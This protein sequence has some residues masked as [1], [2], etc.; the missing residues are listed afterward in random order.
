MRWLLLVPLLALSCEG[1]SLKGT[2]DELCAILG[3]GEGEELECL[4][5]GCIIGGESEEECDARFGH[6]EPAPEPE[7]DET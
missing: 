7:S 4:H 3:Y 5:R 6:P 1:F 2:Q